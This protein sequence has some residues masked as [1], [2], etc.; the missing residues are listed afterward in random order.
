MVPQ[1]HK[2][3]KSIQN[4]SLW[5]HQIKAVE[6]ARRYICSK[7]RCSSL[8]QMPTGTGKSGV[9]AILA[10]LF[11]D[12]PNILIV[13]PWTALRDQLAEDI[14]HKFWNKIHTNPPR[15]SKTVVKIVPSTIKEWLT[16]N[17][18]KDTIFMCTIQTLQAMYSKNYLKRNFM[19][20]RRG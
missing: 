17:K 10:K 9:I 2:N 19:S 11:N 16:K 1:K 12:T 8:I 18:N 14:E 13:T 5:P 4:L 3:Y 6:I 20:G 7:S 15:T